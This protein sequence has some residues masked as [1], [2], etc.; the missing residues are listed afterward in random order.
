MASLL[1]RC[2][3]SMLRSRLLLSSILYRVLTSLSTAAVGFSIQTRT[4]EL[5]GI[6]RAG[7]TAC[8]W[9]IKMGFVQPHPSLSIS[10]PDPKPSS[11]RKSK[12]RPAVPSN[13][14]ERAIVMSMVER[15]IAMIRCRRGLKAIE[16]MEQVQFLATYTTWLRECAA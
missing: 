1:S 15:V 7:L 2:S 5:G 10:K 12:S 4:D 11:S 9:A 3:C 6:G 13:E 8:A 14:E 16:S